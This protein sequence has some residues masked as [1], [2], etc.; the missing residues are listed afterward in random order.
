[1]NGVRSIFRR[2]GYLLTAL[3]AAV[4]LAA[5]SGTAWAQTLTGFSVSSVTV[6]EAD[7]DGVEVKVTRSG[8]DTDFNAKYGPI[9]LVNPAGITIVPAGGTHNN[10]LDFEDDSNEITLTITAVADTNWVSEQR[11]LTLV[12]AEGESISNATLRV[13]VSDPAPV[14]K[15]SRDSITLSD[16]T[17]ATVTMSVEPVGSLGA[18]VETDIMVMVDPAN[19]LDDDALDDGRII[20]VTVGAE[21][22]PVAPNEMGLFPVSFSA[23]NGLRTEAGVA[24]NIMADDDL[25]NNT[26]PKV[27]FS[28]VPLSA[29]SDGTAALGEIVGENSLTITL[30]SAGTPTSSGEDIGIESVEVDAANSDG[31]VNEGTT[32]MVTVTL[33]EDWTAAT[34]AKIT[35]AIGVPKGGDGGLKG[36][37][38]IKPSPGGGPA[39]LLLGSMNLAVNKDQDEVSIALLVNDDLDAVD[40]KFVITATLAA[41][42][43][44]TGGELTGNFA[45][46]IVDDETQTYEFEVKTDD[47]EI[48]EDANFEVTLRRSPTD[49][50]TKM[51]RSS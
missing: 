46:T 19:A 7:A 27:T 42:P 24:L 13:T 29:T 35:L 16:D 3:A 33:T 37:A 26:I 11:L 14:A 17:N 2:K 34:A 38:E 31:K 30:P 4:L 39:D 50:R 49:P 47:D 25:A 28:F 32:T 5:S 18:V 51:W 21:T 45:G 36:E 22:E 15:F 6:D 48:V 43:D 20:T 44:V 10:T 1:M 41:V 8:D 40:E 23:S 9:T 12:S